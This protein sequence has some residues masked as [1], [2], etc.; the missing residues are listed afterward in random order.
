MAE[1]I[2]TALSVQVDPDVPLVPN[3]IRPDAER[4]PDRAGGISASLDFGKRHAPIEISFSY[5]WCKPAD[6]LAAIDHL[7]RALAELR[8]LVAAEIVVEDIPEPGPDGDEAT[9]L[10]AKGLPDGVDF[11]GTVDDFLGLVAPLT[12]DEGDHYV[13]PVA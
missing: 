8:V 5:G 13:R 2:I 11:V 10:V 1:T 4:Y 7:H 12:P 9:R 3:I 6:V